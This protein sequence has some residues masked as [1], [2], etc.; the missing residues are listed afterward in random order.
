[1]IGGPNPDLDLDPV[2]D[3]DIVLDPDLAFTEQ[4]PDPDPDLRS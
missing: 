2:P 4:H 1:M 3:H